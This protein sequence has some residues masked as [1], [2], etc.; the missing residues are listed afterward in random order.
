MGLITFFRA[1]V[2]GP[3][4]RAR[5]FLPQVRRHKHFSW[6]RMHV[7]AQFVLMGWFKKVIADRMAEFADPVFLDPLTYRTGAVWLAIIAYAIQLY[8]DFSGYT[9]MA[10]GIA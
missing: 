9:D 6:L 10:I 2:A 3:I 8:F 5:D 7:G 4:G 1:L